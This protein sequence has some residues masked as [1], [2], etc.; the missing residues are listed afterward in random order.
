[1]VARALFIHAIGEKGSTAITRNIAILKDLLLLMEIFITRKEQEWKGA[2]T[3]RLD[4]E[5]G[6]MVGIVM[7]ENEYCPTCSIGKV[8]ISSPINWP[9][10]GYQPLEYGSHLK[11]SHC[12]AEFMSLNANFMPDL[13]RDK[14]LEGAREFLAA[15]GRY[16]KLQKDFVKDAHD[17]QPELFS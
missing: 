8:Y 12:P 7:D 1:M 17:S 3:S 5:S 10:V 4:Y 2:L 6:E 13:I 16:G 15:H 14:G 9:G 11:C